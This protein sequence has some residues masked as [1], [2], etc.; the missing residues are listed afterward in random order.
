MSWLQATNS[1]VYRTHC[2]MFMNSAD[3][4]IIRTEQE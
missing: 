1:G 3:W 4:E 2:I